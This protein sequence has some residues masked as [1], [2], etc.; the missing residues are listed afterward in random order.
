M[1]RKASRKLFGS[2][3]ISG[4]YNATITPEIA[5]KLGTSL[6]TVI[7]SKGIYIVN[8]DE[9]NLSKSIKSSIISGIYLL[10]LW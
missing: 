10:D 2:R 5:V 7:K 3:N 8:S 4:I 1:G 9:H 6:A